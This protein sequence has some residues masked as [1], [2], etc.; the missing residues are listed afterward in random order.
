[1][2]PSPVALAAIARCSSRL[3]GGPLGGLA[4]LGGALAPAELAGPGGQ[5][6][7]APLQPAA[8]DACAFTEFQACPIVAPAALAAAFAGL[9]ATVEAAR[10]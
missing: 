7:A 9:L 8:V 6:Q 4:A 3:G 1:M 2:V 10:P 5:R